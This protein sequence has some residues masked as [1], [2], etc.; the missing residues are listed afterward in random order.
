[1]CDAADAWRYLNDNLA[2]VE[3]EKSWRKDKGKKGYWTLYDSWFDNHVY[4]VIMNKKY[5]PEDILNIY[6]QDP[7]VL[8]PWD[9][10]Y[11][12]IR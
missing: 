5:V 4:N 3:V 2:Y 1:M 12:V 6:E 7:I 9:P 11:A 8:P 10:M